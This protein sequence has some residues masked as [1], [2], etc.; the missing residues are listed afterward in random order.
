MICASDIR[1]LLQQFNSAYKLFGFA[2]IRGR[3]F[4]HTLLYSVKIAVKPECLTV[5]LADV[6]RI[7]L[8]NFGVTENAEVLPHLVGAR[9]RVR[10]SEPM[11]AVID[12]ISLS[13]P[14]GQISARDKMTLTNYGLMAAKTCVN[15][16]A[17][18]PNAASDY[19]Y[20][21][22]KITFFVNIYL[23]FTI[24]SRILTFVILPHQLKMTIKILYFLL[25]QQMSDKIH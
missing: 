23:H 22:H 17:E 11:Y 19:E 8:N 13:V 4:K 12:V 25:K 10:T 20:F 18:T 5:M 16:G 9:H 3:N 15:S 2:L 6:K 1:S 24:N 7:A 21:R 14:A